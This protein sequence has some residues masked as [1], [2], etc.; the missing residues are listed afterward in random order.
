[1]GQRKVTQ[2][3]VSRIAIGVFGLMTVAMILLA[4]FDDHGALAVGARRQT[5]DELKGQV[6]TIEKQNDQ[7]RKDIENF[8]S[9]LPTIERRAREKLKLVK[10]GEIILQLPEEADPPAKEPVAK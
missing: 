4:V 7:L 3:L 6:N 1:M 10:P 2:S 9:D 5:R 8:N